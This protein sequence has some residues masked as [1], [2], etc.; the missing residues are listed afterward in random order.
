[1]KSSDYGIIISTKVLPWTNTQ[2]QRIQ[3][4]CKRDS[5]TTWRHS[6]VTNGGSLTMEDHSSAAVELVAKFFGGFSGDV[7]CVGSDADHYYFSVI[8]R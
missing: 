5:R 2:S 6:R 1:M 3:A 4:S 7:V 8:A